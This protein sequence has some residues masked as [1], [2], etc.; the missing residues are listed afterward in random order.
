MSALINARL[1]PSKREVGAIH[2]QFINNSQTMTNN[3]IGAV[4]KTDTREIS[5]YHAPLGRRQGKLGNA[6]A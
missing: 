5:R 3:E 2:K 6:E 1:G 4:I